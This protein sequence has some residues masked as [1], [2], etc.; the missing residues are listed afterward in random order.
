MNRIVSILM[1]V[2]A[3]AITG[4]SNDGDTVGGSGL[5]EADE[6]IISAE[7][8]GRV[9]SVSF[10]EG[11]QV[12]V[13][14]TL[15]VIDPSRLELEL[16]SARAGEKVALAQ[17]ETA[18]VQLDKAVDAEAFATGELDRFARLLKS[19]TTTQ[20]QF[21]QLE[22][23]L[24]QA[25]LSKKSA[26]AAITTVEAELAKIKAD[27]NRIS[28]V[29]IDCY[30]LAPI[31]G[32]VTQKYIEVGELLSAGK[33]IAKIS[34]LGSLW[35]KIYLPAGDFANVKTG[36]RATIDTESGGKTFEGEVVWT[37]EEAEFTPKNVQTEKSRANLVY[38]VKVRVDNTDGSLKIGMP[39]FVMLG[40]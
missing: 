27:I 26:Q 28:R 21:D 12:G 36:D 7:T 25:A 17:L 31:G 3:L 8:S 14:D 29:L 1:A 5:L 20:K 15:L 2:T 13:A 35:V 40:E 16:A 34:Q 11:T 18:R 32:V 23:E 19:G 10:S 37:S 38:A 39:V 22:F 9:L 4:C 24:T 33:P 30:P 6:A